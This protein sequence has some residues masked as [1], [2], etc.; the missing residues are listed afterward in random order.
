[1]TRM[2][3]GD[4]IRTAQYLA[5]HDHTDSDALTATDLDTAADHAGAN[6]P[7]TGHDRAVVRIAL[8]T[9]RSAQ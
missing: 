5:D 6:R 7:A 1:M 3:A 8:D 2:T 4:A 9:L